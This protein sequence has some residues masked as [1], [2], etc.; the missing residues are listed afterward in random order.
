VFNS[1]DPEPPFSVP[2]SANLYHPKRIMVNFI[3]KIFARYHYTRNSSDESNFM[4]FEERNP[5]AVAQQSLLSSPPG[6]SL[7]I[8]QSFSEFGLMPAFIFC[9]IEDSNFVPLT[10]DDCQFIF[11]FL[12][13]TCV[14]LSLSDSDIAIESLRECLAWF[15]WAFNGDVSISSG[16]R[17]RGSITYAP[18]SKNKLGPRIIDQKYHGSSTTVNKMTDLTLRM[19]LPDSA[20]LI[21]NAMKLLICQE[22]RILVSG[23]N[24]MV[25][26]KNDDHHPQSFFQDPITSVYSLP[27]SR[28]FLSE[29]QKRPRFSNS[30]LN[31]KTV[32]RLFSP[33]EINFSLIAYTLKIKKLLIHLGLLKNLLDY[34]FGERVPKG[35]AATLLN[36]NS[37]SGPNL[38]DDVNEQEKELWWL[39]LS[40][41]FELISGCKESKEELD[42]V[43]GVRRFVTVL[44]Q[45]LENFKGCPAQVETAF[46]LLLIELTIEGPPISPPMPP[47]IFSSTNFPKSMSSSSSGERISND[48]LSRSLA[49]Q[50][51]QITD[52]QQS[53]NWL[54]TVPPLNIFSTIYYSFDLF[55]IWSYFILHPQ[56]VGIAEI[57]TF[58]EDCC[59][60]ITYP[61]FV[62]LPTDHLRTSSEDPSQQSPY[63]EF[64][65]SQTSGEIVPRPSTQKRGSRKVISSASMLSLN[66]ENRWETESI[67]RLS[68]AHGEVASRGS[69]N[70]HQSIQAVMQAIKSTPAHILLAP[71]T[72]QSEST[73]PNENVALQ[74]RAL[75]SRGEA[76]HRI[77]ITETQNYFSFPTFYKTPENNEVPANYSNFLV[78]FDKNGCFDVEQMLVLC[79]NYL[80]SMSGLTKWLNDEVFEDIDIYEESPRKSTVESVQNEWFHPDEGTN[81][82]FPA[83]FSVDGYYYLLRKHLSLYMMQFI[84][85]EKASSWC[86]TLSFCK[87]RNEESLEIFLSLIF[88]TSG[89]T[90]L[91]FLQFLLVL[92]ESNPSN[93]RALG[94]SNSSTFVLCSLLSSLTSTSQFQ[95]SLGTI[96]THVFN[97]VNNLTSL[98]YLLSSCIQVATDNNQRI[99]EN[100][101]NSMIRK[102]YIVGKSVEPNTIPNSYLQFELKDALKSCL[103][104]PPF[105]D[106]GS[107]SNGAITVS[108]WIRVGSSGNVPVLSLLQLV[109][110]PAGIIINVFLRKL[111]TKDSATLQLCISFTKK[112]Q[113][114]REEHKLNLN[115]DFSKD[116]SW[117][118]AINH[119]LGLE[120]SIELNNDQEPFSSKTREMH[121]SISNISQSLVQ[122]LFPDCIVD[123]PWKE[124]GAWHLFVLSFHENGISCYIDGNERPVLYCSPFGYISEKNISQTPKNIGNE[125]CSLHK[126]KNYY[127]LLIH[128][129][130]KGSKGNSLTAALGGL[131]FEKSLFQEISSNLGNSRN[132]KGA[133]LPNSLESVVRRMMFA[134]SSTVRGFSGLI[135]DIVFIDGKLDMESM[136]H[137]V[138]DGPSKGL[139]HIRGKIISSLIQQLPFMNAPDIKSPVI[140]TKSTPSRSSIVNSEALFNVSFDA[141]ANFS[142]HQNQSGNSFFILRTT[143]LTKSLKSFGGLKSLL[144]LFSGE[145]VSLVVSGLRILSN[146]IYE[147]E[148]YQLFQ[149]ENFDRVLLSTFA[150]AKVQSIEICQV[151]FDMATL[152]SNNFSQI[153]SSSIPSNLGHLEVNEKIK[154]IEILKLVVDL[155]LISFFNYSIGR[156]ALEWIKQLISTSKE[157]LFLFLKHI[158]IMPLQ[159]LVSKW[160][161]ADFNDIMKLISSE[162]KTLSPEVSNNS[163]VDF[164][165]LDRRRV[166][167]FENNSSEINQQPN[168]RFASR[169]ESIISTVTVATSNT[170]NTNNSGTSGNSNEEASALRPI[171][172]SDRKSVV[173]NPK[174]NVTLPVNENM[175]IYDSAQDFMVIYKVHV[176]STSVFRVVFSRLFSEN[177]L[178]SFL[179]SSSETHEY[180]NGL[181]NNFMVFII[182]CSR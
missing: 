49:L 182:H 171:D 42:N 65:G 72:I 78:S 95:E 61:D 44:V 9:A 129:L 22:L 51:N 157:N 92:I 10:L 136:L 1:N 55:P 27:L 137:L 127:E 155:S 29:S 142:F 60:R 8:A 26:L 160:T 133:Y 93:A 35:I 111:K 85:A 98:R 74:R 172:L 47:F 101:L 124:M 159:I 32:P 102:L 177:L 140:T 180:M 97:Y 118:M 30:G 141:E 147:D 179:R 150:Q 86:P 84:E 168:N 39:H 94:Y 46:S 148:E 67:G 169:H 82:S 103:M 28:E 100:T 178:E 48:L 37:K 131:M 24:D 128:S 166:S 68:T 83:L 161:V 50:N 174:P 134:Y 152:Q 64:E 113:E 175:K 116:P 122:F 112:S 149:Q 80:L 56:P 33:T 176:L 88:A 146:F 170:S 156:T 138:R 90:R 96:L 114:T 81:S 120:E 2:P 164:S 70:S 163:T 45:F 69:L 4:T 165:E 6:I 52:Q 16:I 109:G 119:I 139:Q 57:N 75:I 173:I 153:Q 123:Y 121:S 38:Y 79:H 76:Y 144:P 43:F 91:I 7:K 12:R 143:N 89:R 106:S 15:Q 54:Q 115:E 58:I 21:T 104:L 158:G 135:G 41:L 34:C 59:S 162:Q 19:R 3:L 17:N 11:W 14:L 73:F 181:I 108:C 145:N 13:E 77:D 63:R 154:R 5:F 18:N 105:S 125:K 20:A 167:F 40:F 25:A 31:R 126:V 53:I 36:F 71:T 107:I 151:L 23:F 66:D 132:S 130:E 117:N 87:F 110:E 99:S 62:V